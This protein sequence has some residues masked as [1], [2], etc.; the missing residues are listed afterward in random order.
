MLGKWIKYRQISFFLIPTAWFR[1]TQ[2]CNKCCFHV[3]FFDVILFQE[4]QSYLKNMAAPMAPLMNI[5]AKDQIDKKFVLRK[6]FMSILQKAINTPKKKILETMSLGAFGLRRLA[7][8][9]TG[10]WNSQNIGWILLSCVNETQNK[11]YIAYYVIQIFG[12]SELTKTWDLGGQRLQ[13]MFL[14]LHR[15]QSCE[16]V[17]SKDKRGTALIQLYSWYSLKLFQW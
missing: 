9:G 15:A 13:L 3:F 4:R 6:T 11:I 8:K 1:S 5:G 10:W 17:L 2:V 7:S 14:D 12:C 16:D